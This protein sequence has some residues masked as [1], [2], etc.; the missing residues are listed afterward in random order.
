MGYTIS[1]ISGSSIGTL[2]GGLYAMDALDDFTSWML[3]LKRKDVFSLMDFTWNK[4]GVLKGE[5]V[6]NKMRTFIPDM[7]IEE[8]SIPFS[9]V[10]CD[11]VNLREVV[12]KEGSFYDAVRASISIPA[13]FTPVHYMETTLVDGGVLN[14]IPIK[15]VHRQQGDML[16]VV[17]VNGSESELLEEVPLH[18][19]FGS[20]YTILQ[21]TIFAMNNR[22]SDLAL[23]L[24]KPDVT[25][26]IPRNTCG[27]WD[28]H[29]A[30]H[31]IA[32]G[33]E[34]TLK[35]MDILNKAC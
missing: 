15:H 5:K 17:N 26:T 21:Q 24:Y 2:V 30:E 13:I 35:E 22:I 3:D 14:P 1:S 32:L 27:P 29:K 23:E 11:I 4:S 25:I 19:A 28:Y 12:F 18:R 31:L 16:V 8:M 6:F 33:R 7:L 9:A 10:S 20:Y 34:I